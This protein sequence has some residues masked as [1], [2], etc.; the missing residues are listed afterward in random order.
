MSVSELAGVL[1]ITPNWSW[2]VGEGRRT[3]RGTRLSGV[4]SD[5]YCTFDVAAGEDGEVAEHVRE[6]FKR[7]NNKREFIRRVC[8]T[9]GS[10]AF[11]VFWYPNGDT[12]EVFEGSLLLA[13]GEVGIALM[14]NVY[15]DR[16]APIGDADIA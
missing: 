3:P 4:Y 1:P 12:G 7:M 15:D 8:S 16:N 14:L 6:T 11:Y 9:G 10:A 13:L 5:S 2:Q